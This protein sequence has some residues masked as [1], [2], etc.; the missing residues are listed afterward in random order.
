VRHVGERRQERK[1]ESHEEVEDVSSRW[2]VGDWRWVRM[3]LGRCGD[4][5]LRDESFSL[6]TVDDATAK[7]WSFSIGIFIVVR[8]QFLVFLF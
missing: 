6:L 8:K 1:D 7:R 2:V 5:L 4:I 3:F